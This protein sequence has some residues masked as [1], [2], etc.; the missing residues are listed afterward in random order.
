MPIL[1]DSPPHSV[2]RVNV[3]AV[4]RA[5]THVTVAAVNVKASSPS[6]A[7][8]WVLSYPGLCRIPGTGSMEVTQAYKLRRQPV[9]LRKHGT[10]TARFDVRSVETVRLER[11]I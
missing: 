3:R 6:T 8:Q 10:L 5:F 11:E 2:Y 7:A 1:S 4:N 9:W